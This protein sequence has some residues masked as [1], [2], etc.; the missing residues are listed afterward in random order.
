MTP[1]RIA[2]ARDMFDNENFAIEHEARRTGR[3]LC[4]QLEAVTR[5]WDVAAAISVTVDEMCLER[6]DAVAAC[7]DRYVMRWRKMRKAIADLRRKADYSST[8]QLAAGYRLAIDEALATIDR[9]VSS[10]I[11]DAEE[12]PTPVFHPTDSKSDADESAASKNVEAVRGFTEFCK[13]HPDYRFWQSLRNW[14][15]ARF[16]FARTY[17]DCVG[18]NLI[19]TF[20]L[21]GG[22]LSAL[23]KDVKLE[24]AG[25]DQGPKVTCSE[26]GRLRAALEA[27]RTEICNIW[28]YV[29]RGARPEALHCVGLA[30]T[31]IDA[32]LA[33]KPKPEG[34]DGNDQA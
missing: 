31:G 5:E 18:G 12:K 23:P 27:A 24:P 13:A 19:D 30:V 9:F 11:P 3:W 29:D 15:G 25:V 26:C 20:Y 16:I 22:N 7:E 1:E 14:S 21:E 8:R 28:R 34:I 10:D 33:S 2:E 4:D 32:A 17:G 6:L